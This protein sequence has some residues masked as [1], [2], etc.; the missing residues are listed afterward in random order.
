MQRVA[1]LSTIPATLRTP[2]LMKGA[3]TAVQ[4]AAVTAVASPATAP[5][6]AVAPAM[7]S[8]ARTTAAKAS[9]RRQVS[10]SA[11]P[12]ATPSATTTV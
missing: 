3:T 4:R 10:S 6:L 5:G 1:T 12:L 11:C 9:T 7:T 2:E 8:L